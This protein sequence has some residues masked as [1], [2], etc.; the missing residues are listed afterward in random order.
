MAEPY[1]III[2]Y[3][4]TDPGLFSGQ[5]A[6]EKRDHA[7]TT[8]QDIAV[9]ASMVRDTVNPQK[10]AADAFT[11]AMIDKAAGQGIG[12][13]QITVAGHSLGGTPAEIEAAKYG[14]ADSTCNALIAMRLGDHDGQQ[15]FD[16]TS[17]D[18]LLEPHRLRDTVQRYADR[19]PAST[20]SSVC[21]W[22]RRWAA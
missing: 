6:A 1:E 3:R 9:D 10:S 8:V 22:Q 21:P 17:S 20:P 12:R 18:N 4:G 15:Y 13:D 16:S 11:Q 7:L 5:T 2:A 19:V 14:L